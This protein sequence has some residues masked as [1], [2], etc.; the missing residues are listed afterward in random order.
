[1]TDPTLRI[2]NRSDL[3]G[4]EVSL[5]E[6]IDVLTEAFTRKADGLVDNPAKPKVTPQDSAFVNAMPAFIGGSDL[7]GIKWVSGYASNKDRGEPYIYGSML[8]NDAKTGRPIAL[9]DGGYLTDIRTPAVSG[10]VL[11]QLDRS[12]RRLAILGAGVQGRGHLAVALEMCPS[13]TE[14]AVFDAHPERSEKLLQDATGLTTRVADTP[15]DAIEGADLV[16]STLSRPLDPKLADTTL[17]E[18]AVIIPID[19]DDPWHAD[20]I[21]GASL[22]AVDDRDQWESVREKGEY[23]AGVRDP[24]TEL[25]DIVAGKVQ[26]PSSGRLCFINCG[27]AMADVALADLFL[28]RA[29]DAGVGTLV[30]FP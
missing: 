18:D 27:V 22:F 16:I 10:L 2:L 3:A 7:L 6:H 8:L 25:A 15:E 13:L 23:F 26:I 9:L 4:L 19:Y 12:P 28:R 21:N 30:D 5:T 29:I 20:A 14:V 1:M 11:S 24:D 17:A